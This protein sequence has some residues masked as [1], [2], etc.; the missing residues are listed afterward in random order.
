MQ[1]E[2]PFVNNTSLCFSIQK[3]LLYTYILSSE[4]KLVLCQMC[5]CKRIFVFEPIHLGVFFHL[6]IAKWKKSLYYVKSDLTMIDN[7]QERVLAF[8]L[9]V[10][11]TSLPAVNLPHLILHVYV[12]F[13]LERWTTT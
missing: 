13:R 5:L 8:N 2:S 9:L 12:V 10:F 3:F 1:F 6:V 11:K 4:N 7:V